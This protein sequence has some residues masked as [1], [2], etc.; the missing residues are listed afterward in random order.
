MDIKRSLSR[1][2]AGHISLEPESREGRAGE[3]PQRTAFSR[4]HHSPSDSPRAMNVETSASAG[5]RCG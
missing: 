2:R 3:M 4:G 1:F 5:L